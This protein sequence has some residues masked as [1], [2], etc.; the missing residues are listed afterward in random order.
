MCKCLSL[1]L[2]RYLAR[3]VHRHISMPLGWDESMEVN[4]FFSVKKSD[5]EKK[6]DA[7]TKDPSPR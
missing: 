2:P 6:T 1:Y 3:M 7:F 5:Q 4:I